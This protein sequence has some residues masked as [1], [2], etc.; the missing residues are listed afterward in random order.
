MESAFSVAV[1]VHVAIDVLHE[2]SVSGLDRVRTFTFEIVVRVVEESARCP[3][4]SLE[5]TEH[6]CLDPLE[7]LTPLTLRLSVLST[8]MVAKPSRII[9]NFVKTASKCLLA[10]IFFTQRKGEKSAKRN[11]PRPKT[12][13][14]DRQKKKVLAAQR[15][16]GS[17]WCRTISEVCARATSPEGVVLVG[18]IYFSVWRKKGRLDWFSKPRFDDAAPTLRAT[19]YPYT[20]RFRTKVKEEPLATVWHFAAQRCALVDS[21]NVPCSM[22]CCCLIAGVMDHVTICRTNSQSSETHRS[23]DGNGRDSD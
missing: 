23:A 22:A 4:L 3:A 15:R 18:P 20:Q 2:K 1:V 8:S 9:P 14:S 13:T 6:Q 7:Q 10:P 17:V 21:T 16:T 5:M 12:R 11:S 19:V